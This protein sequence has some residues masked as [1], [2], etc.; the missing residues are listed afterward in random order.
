MFMGEYGHSLDAKGRMIVPAKFREALG[1]R[2]V[3]ARSLDR[4]L[5]I[6]AM[7]DWEKFVARLTDIPY[8]VKKQRQLVR[9]FLSGANEAELDR[10]G[11]VLIPANLREAAEIDK[12]V[13]LVGVGSRIE[14]WS[15]ALWD[16][17]MT[18]EELG[19]INEI[20]EEM[21]GNGFEI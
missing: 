13:V 18:D 7:E 15:K 20:A 21:L 11:R 9:Y 17:A 6:Y 16:Q 14:V 10:Q 4:C 5:C 1:D 2:C 19:E 8:N 12:D 3:I